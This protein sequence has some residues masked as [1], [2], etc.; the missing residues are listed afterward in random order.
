MILA[1]LFTTRVL[2]GPSLAFRTSQILN[3]LHLAFPAVRKPVLGLIAKLPA[4]E[5]VIENRIGRYAINPRTESVVVSSLCFEYF[6]RDWVTGGDARRKSVFLD[7][8]ANIGVYSLL[9]VRAGFARV[10]AFEP[11][12]VTFEALK[13]NL[14][15]SKARRV[16]A[17]N[18]GLGARKGRLLFLQHERNPGQS[19]VI[20]PR[21]ARSARGW[22]RSRRLTS[23]RST[24]IS[25]RAASPRPR[26][27]SSR[28]M[29]RATSR[30]S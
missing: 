4:G 26:C 18:K 15:L 3:H 8:G 21:S 29:S 16:V 20:S 12:P 11:N 24:P 30:A 23:S 6:L 10:V 19:R 22:E 7:I 28:L 5:V 25:G 14:G 2:R 27:A 13:R 17:V 1:D 9:A